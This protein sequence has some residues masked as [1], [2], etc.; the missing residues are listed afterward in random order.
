MTAQITDPEPIEQA[1]ASIES[2]LNSLEESNV[3]RQYTLSPRS[4]ALVLLQK[5]STLWETLAQ[6]HKQQRRNKN[7]TDSYAKSTPISRFDDR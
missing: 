1:I 3:L 6:D 4:L 2:W 5:D 7:I